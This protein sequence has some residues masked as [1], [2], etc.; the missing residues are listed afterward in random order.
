MTAHP[1]HTG[2][3]RPRSGLEV[4][5]L[6]A[7]H[8]EAYQQRY[9]LNAAQSAVVRDLVRCRTAAL[10]GHLDE[11]TSPTCSFERPAYN[12]C[13]NRHCP[14]CQ[15]FA[16]ARWVEQRM[17]R[18]L[19]THYFHVVFTLPAELRALAR[20]NRALVFGLLLQCAADTLL[21]LGR[22]PQWLG[23][24]AQLGV[25]TVLHTWTRDLRFHPHAHCIVTGGGLALDQTEWRA[26]PRDFLFPVRVLSA[27]FRGKLLAAIESA[28]HSGELIVANEGSDRTF[29]RR[30]R[31][32]RTKGWVVYAKRP[33][34]GPE[35]VHR[36]LG[37][38]THR[39]AISNARLLT[40]EAGDVTFRTRGDAAVTLPAVDFL[41]RFLDHVLPA[42]FVKIRHYGLL[43]SGNVSTRLVRARSLLPPVAAKIDDS[44]DDDSADDNYGDGDG[45][46]DGEINDAAALIL[47]LTGV[48]VRTCPRCRKPT[49]RRRPL[50]SLH[51][52]RAPP[53]L[54]AVAA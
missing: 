27:L 30:L 11:C 6:I 32:L 10:G 8:L 12:S 19:P 26:A 3:L 14:K 51:L 28:W 9:A 37:R 29:L 25:T 48:D 53:P 34:G 24:A 4:A 15:G 31:K 36:Y 20:R 7:E 38:Y 45:D 43:A 5:K 35:Q 52:A 22:D 17:Q 13:R 47:V 41:R 21:T 54:E 23:A 33:F 39:V 50:P 46:G 49:L 40:H 2:T 1:C 18:V 44:A 42:G 16:Q